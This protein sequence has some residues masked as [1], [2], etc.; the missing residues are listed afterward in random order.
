M[1][2]KSFTFHFDESTTSQTKKQHDGYVKFFSLE[3]GE[4]VITYCETSFVGRF[5]APDIVNHLKTFA[6][7]QNLNLK[8]LLNLGMDSPNVN[9]AFKNLVIKELK[10]KYH[11]TL[12]DLGTGSFHSAKNGF[13]KLIKEV[14]DI[15]ELE[16]MAIDFHF[17]F[18]YP[19]CRREDFA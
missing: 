6:A 9:S 14:D 15:V 3:S 17:F 13:G 10:E 1:Q 7:K 2:E 18:K 5:S 4:V 19:G 11:T 16:K 12:A 8:L